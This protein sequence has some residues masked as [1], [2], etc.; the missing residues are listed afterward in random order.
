MSIERQAYARWVQAMAGAIAAAH[1]PRTLELWAR[2]LHTSVG[3]LRS[4][5]QC[6]AV[7][8]R[9]SLA[10][11]RAL[12]ATRLANASGDRPEEFLDV[13]DPRTARRLLKLAGVSAGAAREVDAIL[14]AQALIR[15]PHA[16]A[17]LARV[18][19]L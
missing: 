9:R 2:E 10:L 14:R 17:E 15:N 6:A 13:A 7:P 16:V 11:A 19:V 5:C 1:D 4:W 8:A 12:R 3:A 18:L